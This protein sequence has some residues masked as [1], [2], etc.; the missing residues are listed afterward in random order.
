MMVS[1]GIYIGLVWCYTYSPAVGLSHNSPDR[2]LRAMKTMLVWQASCR[3][4]FKKARRFR[5]ESFQWR[6]SQFRYHDNALLTD[7]YD[8]E[9]VLP[10]VQ[11]WQGPLD[12]PF[13]IEETKQI[14]QQTW[15]ATVHA[16]A[17]L[18]HWIAT[19]KV[20]LLSYNLNHSNVS[21]GC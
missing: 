6:L 18:M 14:I 17:A 16:E 19:V 13:G 5:S 7:V 8:V 15:D 9:T 20:S 1:P 4:V 10:L 12:G 2:L 11:A 3:H 21:L